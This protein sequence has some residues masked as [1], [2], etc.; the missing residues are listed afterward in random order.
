MLFTNARLQH[1]RRFLHRKHGNLPHGL[2][3][4]PGNNR[5]HHLQ[6]DQLLPVVPKTDL[7][8][9]KSLLHNPVILII[10]P[11]EQ[12]Q[13]LHVLE[14]KDRSTQPDVPQNQQ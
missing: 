7:K 9:K 5:P 11:A 8:P 13:H 1:L 3:L 6:A 10:Q 14:E 2:I 4:Q 12:L